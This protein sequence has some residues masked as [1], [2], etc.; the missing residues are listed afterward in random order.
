[1]KVTNVTYFK[2]KQNGTIVGQGEVTLD[3]CLVIKYRLMQ[4]DKGQWVNWPTDVV[5]KDGKK[6]Y[7]P[8]VKFTDEDTKK[9]IEEEI[10]KVSL[11]YSTNNSAQQ[12]NKSQETVK[13]PS[14]DD[15]PF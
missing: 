3:G 7:Y 8:K 15:I 2:S 1:M 9:Y 11:K 13:N 10:I 4:N 6:N 12:Q 5:E 14:Y